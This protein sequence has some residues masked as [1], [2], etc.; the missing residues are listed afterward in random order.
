[1]RGKDRR[2]G[3]AEIGEDAPF[4]LLQ[5]APG[6]FHGLVKAVEFAIHVSLADLITRDFGARAVTR[7]DG[8]PYPI[9]WR[10]WPPDE[11]LHA[12]TRCSFD[13][14]KGSDS[15]LGQTLQQ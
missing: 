13:S 8:S 10:N 11:R 12:P 7:Y 14:L 6:S 3:L 2:V 5:F 15:A 1:V 9:S 4:E